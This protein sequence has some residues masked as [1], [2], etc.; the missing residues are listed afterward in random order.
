VLGSDDV[1]EEVIVLDGHD[2]RIV[3]PRNSEA[4]LDEHG[5]EHEEFLPYWADLWPSARALAGALEGRAL[6]GAPVLELGCGLGV[7][8]LA[9]ALAGGRVLATDWSAEAVAFAAENARR[10][11]LEIE[12]AVVDWKAPAALLDRAPWPVVIAS[13]VLYEARNAD[14]LLEL[15]P[16]LVDERGE[17]LLADPQR[18]HAARFLTAAAGAWTIT[19]K[20]AGGSAGAVV[21]RM[22]RLTS[23]DSGERQQR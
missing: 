6:R 12:T 20:A 10:N 16:R 5:F 9:A 17:V 14:T 18:A 4:L 2:L 8:A 22:R 21:H 23:P 11:D 7:G 19:T 13:D 15:L 1:V 3:R